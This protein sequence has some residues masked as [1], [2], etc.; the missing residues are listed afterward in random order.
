MKLL[1]ANVQAQGLAVNLP[2]NFINGYQLEPAQK[3]ANEL[4][5]P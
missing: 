2:L 1:Q 4:P 5:V 3:I